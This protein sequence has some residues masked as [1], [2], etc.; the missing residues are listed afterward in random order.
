MGNDLQRTWIQPAQGTGTNDNAAPGIVGESVVSTVAVGSAVGLSNNTPVNITSITLTAGDWDV[1]GV[2]D[3]V[4][5][6]VTA[7]LFQAG[8]SVT[9]AALPSQPGG[10]GLGPDASIANPLLSTVLS[11]SFDQSV[12][13]VRLSIA[14][15]T[16]V[17][18]VAQSSF[19]AGTLTGYGT[20]RARRVR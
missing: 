2:I 1:A 17:Y 8:I 13:P 7:T 14:A 19:S 15:T 10:S 12:G 6:G 5:S 3:F 9:S 11:S 18:L 4:L 16:T 20:L